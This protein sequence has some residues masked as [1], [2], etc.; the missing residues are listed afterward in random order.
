MENTFAIRI[1]L[2]LIPKIMSSSKTVSIFAF[3]FKLHLNQ[4]SITRKKEMPLCVIIYTKFHPKKLFSHQAKSPNEWQYR[5][6]V[7]AEI[8]SSVK[9]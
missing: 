8:Q 2:Y 5:M 1:Y 4:S 6:K 3:F 9:Q 7:P